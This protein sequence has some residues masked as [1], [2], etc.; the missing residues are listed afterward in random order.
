[1]LREF[2]TRSRRRENDREALTAIL[3]GIK[4]IKDDEYCV[5]VYPEG[6]RNATEDTLL[7]FKSGCF[8]IATKTNCPIVVMSIKG[9]DKIKNRYPFKRTTVTLEVVDV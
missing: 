6:T 2:R 3:R 7:P 4:Q 1:M 9:S 8:K 5:G